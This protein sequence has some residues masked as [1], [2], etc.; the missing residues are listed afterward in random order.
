MTKAAAQSSLSPRV[1]GVGGEILA[2][3]LVEVLEQ[4]NWSFR[5]RNRLHLSE[6]LAADGWGSSGSE[7]GI[8]RNAYPVG[9]TWEELRRYQIR[10]RSE[11]AALQIGVR[12][13]LATGETGY[14]RVTV[15]ATS[16]TI[17]TTD[18]DNGSEVTANLSTAA[19]GT[20]KLLVTVEGRTDG[21]STTN[22]LRN[23]RLE[24]VLLAVASLPDPD[25]T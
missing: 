10:V 22:Y 1:F 12:T 21:P 16:T 4:L 9:A 2:E 25:N 8:G 18:A 19:T 13:E 6:N 23:L 20:G 15:G 17:T 11:P 7:I 14:T 3:D 24:D 5:E